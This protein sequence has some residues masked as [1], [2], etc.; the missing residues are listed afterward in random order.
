VLGPTRQ[1]TTP[2]NSKAHALLELLGAFC[3]WR[4]CITPREAHELQGNSS[5]CRWHASVE[6]RHAVFYRVGALLTELYRQH[7]LEA[8]E[9]LQ[10]TPSERRMYEAFLA[11]EGDSLAEK[12]KRAI[13]TSSS[14]LEVTHPND[15]EGWLLGELTTPLHSRSCRRDISRS[16]SGHSTSMSL[17][18]RRIARTRRKSSTRWDWTAS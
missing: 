1:S 5:L 15:E 11:G 9:S 8:D 12:T 13:Q 16:R 7:F 3:M 2:L 18:L 17:V 14:L 4:S 6:V 10:Y